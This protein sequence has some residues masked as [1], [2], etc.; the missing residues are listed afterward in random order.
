MFQ[1]H[2]FHQKRCL[3]RRV[4]Q[5]NS[6]KKFQN[7]FLSVSSILWVSRILI[8]IITNEKIGQ[9][10]EKSEILGV[11]KSPPRI[12]LENLPT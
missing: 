9:K 12:D 5:E 2:V 10:Y 7:K 3:W 4:W 8:Q 11:E 6:G 1:N